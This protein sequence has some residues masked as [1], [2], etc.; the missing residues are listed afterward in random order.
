MA[1]QQR[2]GQ[3]D[4]MNDPEHF[5]EGAADRAHGTHGKG[6]SRES[7]HD[8]P[9]AGGPDGSHDTSIRGHGAEGGADGWGDEASGGS[10]FD[11]RP[12]DGER[13]EVF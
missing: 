1:R 12:N 6:D 3:N 13:G 8:S 5:R 4:P 11:R 7:L 2:S 9:N 10:T